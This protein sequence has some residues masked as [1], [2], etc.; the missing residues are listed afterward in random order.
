M[1]AGTTEW[2]Q[3]K[4]SMPQEWLISNLV[5]YFVFLKEVFSEVFQAQIK[6]ITY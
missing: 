2:L 6:L 4:D 5:K 3:K 1:T